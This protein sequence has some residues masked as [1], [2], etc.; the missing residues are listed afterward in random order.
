MPDERAME[1]WHMIYLLAFYS[2]E[3]EV[4]QQQYNKLFNPSGKHSTIGNCF[5]EVK[6]QLDKAKMLLAKEG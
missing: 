2:R 5:I 6:F 1:K 4:M 3:M